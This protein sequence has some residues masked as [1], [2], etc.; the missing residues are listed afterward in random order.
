MIG[1]MGQNDFSAAGSLF[2]DRLLGLALTTKTSDLKQRF[3]NSEAEMPGPLIDA[4]RDCRIGKLSHV[5]AG[6]TDKE[7]D[8]TMPARTIAAYIGIH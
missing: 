3:A 8:I 1:K 2:S 4:V 5:A 7:T 6:I